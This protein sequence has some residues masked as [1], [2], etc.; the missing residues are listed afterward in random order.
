MNIN[1][2]LSFTVLIATITAC[3]PQTPEW[4]LYGNINGLN[5]QEWSGATNEQQLGTAAYWLLSFERKGWLDD[6][7]LIKNDNFK[8][9][10]ATL[11]NCINDY[12]SFSD[13]ETNAIVDKC[14]QINRWSHLS[15]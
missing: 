13:E 2:F 15:K 6:P 1:N 12:L 10:A 7:R 8:P 4:V 9:T 5:R 14:V 3:S 11:R